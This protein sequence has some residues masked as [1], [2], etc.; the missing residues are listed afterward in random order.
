[1]GD[2]SVVFVFFLECKNFGEN[3]RRAW[4]GT[5]CLFGWYFCDADWEWGVGDWG[6]GGV[7]HMVR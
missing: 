2:G 6:K 7:V 5:G 1:M 3:K 4:V